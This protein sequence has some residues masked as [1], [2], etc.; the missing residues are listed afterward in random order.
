[1][2]TIANLLAGG[3]GAAVMMIATAPD[4]ARVDPPSAQ[5]T[6]P[7][8]LVGE[9]CPLPAPPCG[10]VERGPMAIDERAGLPRNACLIFFEADDSE[11]KG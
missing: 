8:R 6:A 11:S 7:V 5:C 2:T 4:A 10:R 1:M 9:T 3:V